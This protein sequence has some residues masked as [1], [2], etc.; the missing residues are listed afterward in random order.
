MQKLLFL[1]G[2]IG[3]KDQFSV[4]QD[5][6]TG[7]Y[8]IYSMNFS[9][10][11][12]LELPQQDF[13]IPMFANETLSFLDREEAEQVTVFGYSMGGYVGMYLAKHFPARINKLI[14]LAT[15]FYWTEAIAAR[16]TSM[17]N[18][19]KITEKLP[20]FAEVLKERHQPADWKLLLHKTASMLIEMGKASP[21]RLPDYRS[22]T[23]PVKLML[24]DRD[25]MVSLEETTEVYKALPD[26]RLCILPATPH[27]I[28]AVDTGRLAYEIRDFLK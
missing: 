8:D 4:L 25:K 13:S 20:G 26:A 17:L 10:H 14:T 7:H 15:K 3:S 1:H 2:A 21:L 19:E 18:P 23:L 11:G 22:V 6:L 12:G 27:P 5:Q 9:G 16:E 24:G 28:E